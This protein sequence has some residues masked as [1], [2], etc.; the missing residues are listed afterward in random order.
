VHLHC[1]C[2]HIRLTWLEPCTYQD[3]FFAAQSGPSQTNLTSGRC[4]TVTQKIVAEQP[5]GFCNTFVYCGVERGCPNGYGYT[6]NQTSCD[7]KVQLGL[8]NASSGMQIPQYDKVGAAL[9]ATLGSGMA[10]AHQIG[11]IGL[12]L[13]SCLKPESS[14]YDACSAFDASLPSRE[15]S[16]HTG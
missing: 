14:A 8:Y 10:L 16:W 12:N 3:I 7:L 5:G 13:Y 9:V 6:F 2:Q 11:S 4:K 1:F 15:T